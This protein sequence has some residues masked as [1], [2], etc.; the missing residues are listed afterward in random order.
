MLPA[1][2]HTPPARDPFSGPASLP[3]ACSQVTQQSSVVG[4]G[5]LLSR[6]LEREDSAK[7]KGHC[8][9]G[10]KGSTQE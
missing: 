9:E 6:S 7:P 3:G 5:K 1:A 2:S 4:T 10:P 8:W